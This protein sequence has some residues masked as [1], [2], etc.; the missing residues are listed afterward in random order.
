MMPIVFCASFV[1]C[2][3]L[4]A[5]AET[6]CNLRKRRSTR[7]GDDRWDGLTS[8]TDVMERVKRRAAEDRQ[9]A[10]RGTLDPGV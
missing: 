8:A 2:P 1:P 9:A 5:A 4:Y 6:S 7:R 3:R 10:R